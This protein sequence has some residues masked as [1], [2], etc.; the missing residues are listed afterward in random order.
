MSGILSSIS[1]CVP[2]PCCSVSLRGGAE[3]TT[4]GNEHRDAEAGPGEGALEKSRPGTK[5]ERDSQN[6]VG[7]KDRSGSSWFCL[8]P[9]F[10]VVLQPSILPLRC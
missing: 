9:C 1:G 4:R 2:E 7:Q 10:R 5:D 8:D 3:E 6:Q